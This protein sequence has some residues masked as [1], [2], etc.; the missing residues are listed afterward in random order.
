MSEIVEVSKMDKD[1]LAAYAKATHGVD[2]KLA[3][4]INDLRAQVETLDAENAA[5]KE[6]AKITV[7]DAPFVEQSPEVGAAEDAGTR[8]LKHPKTG[9][10]FVYD[11]IVSKVE[12]MI[13]CREDGTPLKL[14]E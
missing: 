14:E 6:E 4:K 12:G 1:A 3:N 2:L 11:A 9:N 5:K 8:Y 13:P 10:V 7:P